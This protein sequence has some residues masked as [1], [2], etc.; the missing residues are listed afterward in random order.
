MDAEKMIMKNL[1]G[2]FKPAI[3]TLGSIFGDTIREYRIKNL[4]RIWEKLEKIQ[5][6]KG[7]T[8][9][10]MRHLSYKIGLP[11]VEFASMEDDSTL[12]E[13]WAHLIS[14][15]INSEEDNYFSHDKIF[16][17]VLAKFSP[18][19]CQVLEYMCEH[20]VHIL[21]KENKEAKS[22]LLEP[23]EILQAIK[24]ESVNYSV[25]KLTSLGCLKEELHLPLKTSLPKAYRVSTLGINL[26]LACG[27]EMEILYRLDMSKDNIIQLIASYYVTSDEVRISEDKHVKQVYDFLKNEFPTRKTMRG[28]EVFQ[29]IKDKLNL[30]PNPI[31]M[32]N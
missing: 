30:K 26:Y 10:S 24:N 5:K 23:S 25:D 17:D 3:T 1:S 29:L 12:Q 11:L 8:S 13:K 6:R 32:T 9:K 7:I 14:S 19:D 27:G 2:L 16:V 20:T 22:T 18:F 4:I 21:L 15:Y 28:E 31:K